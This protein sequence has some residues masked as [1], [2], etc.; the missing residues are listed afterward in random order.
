MNIRVKTIPHKEQRYDTV[1]DWKFED[2]GTFLYVWVS[3]LGDHHEEACIALHEIIEATLCLARG[4]SEKEVTEFDISFEAYRKLGH[5]PEGME[6]GDHPGAPYKKEH[7]FATS[8]ERLFAAEL[9]VNWETYDEKIQ[10]LQ[11]D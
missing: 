1:G 7:F 4:I 10:S 11:F 9:K 3:E 5:Y 6:P 2:E 8:I